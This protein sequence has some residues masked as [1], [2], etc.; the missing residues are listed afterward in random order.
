MSR[1]GWYDEFGYALV[2]TSEGLRE[3]ER[4]RQLMYVGVDVVL[5]CYAVDDRSSFRELLDIVLA[6]GYICWD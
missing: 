4:L 5:L 6:L 2:L 1:H 3:Y